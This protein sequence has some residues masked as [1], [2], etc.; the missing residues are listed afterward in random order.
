MDTQ[1]MVENNAVYDEQQR[2]V[3]IIKMDGQ[4]PLIVK[5]KLKTKIEKII[6]AFGQSKGLNTSH[7]RFL[8]DD[9]RIS[10]TQTVGQVVTADDDWEDSDKDEDGFLQFHISVMVEASGGF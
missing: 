9:S 7:L 1:E 6:N 3:L 4:Q 5:V 8:Y 2:V 10:G